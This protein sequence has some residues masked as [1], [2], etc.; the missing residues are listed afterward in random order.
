MRRGLAGFGRAAQEAGQIGV[1]FNWA[2]FGGWAVEFR[3]AQ[4]ASWARFGAAEV[5]WAVEFRW[6]QFGG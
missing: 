3:W 6:A 4:F 1:E 2:Q 5:K